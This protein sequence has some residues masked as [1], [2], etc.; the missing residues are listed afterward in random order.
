MNTQTVTGTVVGLADS[1]W[2]RRHTVP[3]PHI[4]EAVGTVRRRARA[5]LTAWG[6]T[7]GIA[8][9]ALLVVSELVTDAVVHALPPAELR[10]GMRHTL[11]GAVVRIEV[12]DA[13]TAIR[14]IEDEH[15]PHI[16]EHGRGRV[17]VTA[18]AVRSGTFVSAGQMV[19]WAELVA[20]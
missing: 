12:A 20:V 17:I 15:A 1:P 6:M 4:A 16:D 8:D 2:V 18:L 14:R 5:V 10:L 13:G 9:D 7:C 3:V 19:R 11:E